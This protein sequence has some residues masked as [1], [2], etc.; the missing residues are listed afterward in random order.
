M[1]AE[2]GMAE[3]SNKIRLYSAQSKKLVGKIQSEGVCFSKKD[4]IESKYGESAKIFLAAYRWLAREAP[5]YVPKP[6]GAEFH[7][8]AFAGTIDIEADGESSVLVMDIPVE[9]C[10]LFNLYDWNKI[11]KLQ[12]I[13]KDEQEETLF[14]EQ[15]KAMGI[16]HDSDIMLIN[17]YPDLKK[18]IENSWQS[19]FRYHEQLIK[20]ERPIKAVEGAL[21][22]IR[23]EW[24]SEVRS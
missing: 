14:R 15:I 5:K 2:K 8:W 10:L 3:K 20:N 24:I 6:E 22:Q 18:E 9:E 13:G 16:K 4:Y 21:W 1:G 12:Y 19:L 7:Y 17:F 23:N 11:L